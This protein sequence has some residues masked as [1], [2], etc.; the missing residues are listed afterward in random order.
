MSDSR[1]KHR[2]GYKVGMWIAC[3]DTQ[4]IGKITRIDKRG[5]F[6]QFKESAGYCRGMP[7]LHREDANG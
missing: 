1:P 2:K 6:V 3:D 4:E 5:V 7:A